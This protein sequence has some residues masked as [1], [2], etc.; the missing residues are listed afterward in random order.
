MN[1]SCRLRCVWSN[2]IIQHGCVGNTVL[3]SSL[4]IESLGSVIAD[5]ARLRTIRLL[6]DAYAVGGPRALRSTSFTVTR[7]GNSQATG[8][9]GESEEVRTN[10]LTTTLY[11]SKNLQNAH[12]ESSCPTA[13]PDSTSSRP[14]KLTERFHV[15]EWFWQQLHEAEFALAACCGACN[16]KMDAWCRDGPKFKRR[17]K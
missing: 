14:S 7:S 13:S 11:S 1:S 8:E 5:C 3:Q 12:P 4:S 2:A 15:A 10:E 17:T 16:P 6:E 9:T